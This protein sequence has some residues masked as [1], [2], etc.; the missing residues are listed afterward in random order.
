MSWLELNKYNNTHGAKVKIVKNNPVYLCAD[1]TAQRPIIE[2]A[3][4]I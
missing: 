4:N 1:S 3:Q 2:A